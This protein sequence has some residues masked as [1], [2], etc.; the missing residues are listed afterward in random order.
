MIFNTENLEK[1]IT[2]LSDIEYKFIT[3]YKCGCL[4]EDSVDTYEEALDTIRL[5]LN[6][7]CIVCSYLNE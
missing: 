4:E 1:N 2:K 3:L 5:N 7:Q 6:R